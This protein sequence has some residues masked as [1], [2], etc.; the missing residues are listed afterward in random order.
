MIRV[1]NQSRINLNLSNASVASTGFLARAKGPIS[2]TASRVLSAVPGGSFVKKVGKGLLCAGSAER[3][4]CENCAET[5]TVIDQIKGRNFEVPG[6]GGFMLTGMA[7]N[8]E[9]YYRIGEEVACFESPGDLVE[10]IGF[11]LADEER[12]NAVALAG[13]RRTLEEHTYAHRFSRIFETMG[14]PG[15]PVDQPGAER[16]RP[17]RTKEIT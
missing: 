12:R 1:F 9:E 17:G 6:C 4:T 11:Y 10:K 16:V 8:I 7:D 2:S 3:A 5:S 15:P 13:Y 14:L